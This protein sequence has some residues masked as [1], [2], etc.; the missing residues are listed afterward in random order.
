MPN[1]DFHL[2][3]KAEEIAIC[4]TCRLSQCVGPKAKACPARIADRRKRS[5]YRRQMAR[6]TAHARA[7]RR[8][9]WAELHGDQ[10]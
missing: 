5:E 10:T 8:G 9:Y 6:V 7:D 3:T 4:A 1:R 2:L